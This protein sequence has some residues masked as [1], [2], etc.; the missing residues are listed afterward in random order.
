MVELMGPWKALAAALQGSGECAK[1]DAIFG[2]SIPAWALLWF[3][4]LGVL[5]V[6]AAF[7]RR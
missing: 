3:V 4:A 5:A 6:W 2:V 1:V 7:R